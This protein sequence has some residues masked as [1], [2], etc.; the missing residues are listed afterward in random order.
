MSRVNGRRPPKRGGYPPKVVENGPASNYRSDHYQKFI[1]DC[2]ELVN[3]AGVLDHR[4]RWHEPIIQ[5]IVQGGGQR[6]LA[7]RPRCFGRN[8][9]VADAVRFVERVRDSPVVEL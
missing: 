2:S 8:V 4:G 6:V 9:L 3:H 1:F 7:A 5:K